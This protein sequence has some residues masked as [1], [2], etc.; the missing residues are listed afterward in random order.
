[1]INKLV[2]EKDAS[3]K[4]LKL[5]LEKI[6][7][8]FSQGKAT[9]AKWVQKPRNLQAGPKELD[10]IAVNRH[11][12]SQRYVDSCLET[13]KVCSQSVWGFPKE[14]NRNWRSYQNEQ[15][16]ENKVLRVNIKTNIFKKYIKDAAKQHD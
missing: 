13:E 15:V 1:M 10:I 5:I 3:T 14:V 9:N 11:R 6:T 4:T 12:D 7:T 8:A 16:C 2:L